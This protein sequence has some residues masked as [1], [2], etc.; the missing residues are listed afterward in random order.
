MF[1]TRDQ[2]VRISRQWQVRGGRPLVVAAIVA[3]VVALGAGLRGLTENPVTGRDSMGLTVVS[4][5]FE[6]YTCATCAAGAGYVQAGARSVFVVLPSGCAQPTREATIT[7]HA[8]LDPS[9]G[10]AAYRA[11]ACPTP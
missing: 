7:V 8:R 11:T 1:P 2:P 9:L 6:P 3:A 5:R 4:G 10:T